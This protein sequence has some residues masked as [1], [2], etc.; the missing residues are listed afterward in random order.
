[1]RPAGRMTPRNDVPRGKCGNK[2]VRPLIIKGIN[3]TLP[4]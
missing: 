1:M 3:V 2:A 4:G